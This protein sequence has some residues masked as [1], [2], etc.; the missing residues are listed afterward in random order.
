MSNFIFRPRFKDDYPRETVPSQEH[1][2]QLIET[3][4]WT[5]LQREEGRSLS[6]SVG[7]GEQHSSDDY[8]FSLQDTLDYNLKNLTK[9]A[10]AIGRPKT[11]VMVAPD[12]TRKLKM[13]GVGQNHVSPFTI[14]VLDPGQLIV[15]FAS[16][17]VAVISGSEAVLI[18][19]RLL[20]RS[21]SI[22]SAFKPEDVDGYSTWADQRVEVVINIMRA[23]RRLGH[24]G[25]LVIVPNDCEWDSNVQKP[26]VYGARGQYTPTQ[27][28]L[29]FLN[30]LENK[31]GTDSYMWEDNLERVA[32]SL[33]QFTAID[34]AVVLTP[35]LNVLAFG[36]MLAGNVEDSEHLKILSVDP[37]DHSESNTYIT[38]KDFKGARHQS[39][40]RFVA[41]QKR[42]VAIVV[43]QDGNVTAFVWE[44]TQQFPEG[45]LVV[46]RRL[47]ITLF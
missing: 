43:S 8:T 37:L 19:D 24:G 29:S 40:A 22:W 1:L 26:L 34:G 45:H 4:F 17:N 18:R 42:A 38:L 2:T 6:F 13:W 11:S 32:K 41:C 30:E 39:A 44:K 21:E 27:T 20:F 35:D 23:M 7:Y 25:T 46:Y 28:A 12:S 36:V 5:S 10:P 16:S 9:L 33:A 31:L 47:E 14:K 15:H 3:A